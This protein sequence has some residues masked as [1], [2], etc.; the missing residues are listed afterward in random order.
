MRAT[1]A[2]PMTGFKREIR[3][4]SVS[5]AYDADRGELTEVQNISTLPD[6]VEKNWGHS[7]DPSTDH[8]AGHPAGYSTAEIQVHP[9]GK[10]LYA[11]NRGHDTIAVFAIDQ[12][13]SELISVEHEPTQGRTPRGFGIDPT[14]QYLLVANQDSDNVVVFSIDQDSGALK[15]TGEAASVPTPVCLKFVR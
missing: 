8:L 5:F 6:S 4:S 11:S 3:Y 2:V 12:E 10:F 13:S 9:S 1:D 14:G 7:E 15:L